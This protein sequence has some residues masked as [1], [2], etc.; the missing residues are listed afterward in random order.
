MTSLAD[1]LRICRDLLADGTFS[2]IGDAIR[3]STR[4][5]TLRLDIYRA[6][7]ESALPWDTPLQAVE[8]AL[9]ELESPGDVS[10]R[11]A[12]CGSPAG[13]HAVPG[14]TGSIPACGDCLPLAVADSAVILG[15]VARPIAPA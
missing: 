1:A 4:D 8:A 10:D 9:L 15:L 6:I 3:A 14:L 11:C 12:Y 7:R 5:T 2:L 13:W